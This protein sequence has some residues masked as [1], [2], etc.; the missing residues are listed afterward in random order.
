MRLRDD[1][2]REVAHG[3]VERRIAA[4]LEETPP[5]RAT[6]GELR[7]ARPGEPAG[8]AAGAPARPMNETTPQS[9]QIGVY[10]PWKET[11]RKD[12]PEGRERP[13]GRRQG[14]GRVEGPDPRDGGA[15]AGRIRRRATM[16]P[17]AKSR[18]TRTA[19]RAIHPTRW[20]E[21]KPGTGAAKERGAA[22]LGAASRP[23]AERRPRGRLRRSRRGRRK[24]AI[25]EGRRGGE[26]P[27]GLST[28][29]SVDVGVER[30]F[31]RRRR[32]VNVSGRF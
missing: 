11:G 29:S 9:R 12:T 13:P 17:G 19:R 30:R 6:D 3:S 15:G 23:R 28:P 10:G 26:A 21:L 2:V 4:S 16:T 7:Q 1:P 27:K 18:R 25:S 24:R 5:S 32:K 22:G 14:P 20:I 8:A 31:C